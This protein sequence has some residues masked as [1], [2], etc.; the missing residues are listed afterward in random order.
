[1]CVIRAAEIGCMVKDSTLNRED[2]Q[3]LLKA[4]PF[5]RLSQNGI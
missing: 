5:Q 4:L 1:L 2:L 3:D